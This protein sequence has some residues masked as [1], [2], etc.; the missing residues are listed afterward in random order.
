MKS[1]NLSDWALGHRSLV[2][3]FMIAFMAAGFFAYLQLGRQEDPDF[4]I[5]TMVVQAQ[6]PGAS[7]EEMTRQITDRIEKK[8]E[9]LE[10]LDYTK[11]VTVAGQ[12]TVF[13]Y[14]R[15]STKAADVKPTWIRVRNMIADIKGDFPQG[16]IGP[17]FNDRF[18]DVFGNIYA[19]TSDGLSQR[20]LRDHV[21]DIRA[22]VL[23]VPDVG[24][25]DIL[26]AQDEVIYLEF[27]TRKIAAL[28]LDVHAIMSSLQGQNAVA[29]SGVFQE[30]PERISVR[31][32]GQFTSEASLKAVNLRINDRFFP[33]TDVATI[34]RGYADPARTLFRYNGES[35]IALAIG[36]KSG[37]NLLHFGEALKEEMS[38]ITADLPVGVGVHLVADQPVVVEHAVSGF[39][40]ALFEAVII[41]L[42]ISFLSLGMR[43][44]LVVAI[45]IPLVLAITFVV[46]AYAG[47]SLQRISLGALIIAL[48]LLVDDAMIAVEM[49]VARLEVGDPLEKAAT[50][51]YTSTAFPMLTGTL[52]TVAGF[53][54]IGLNSSNAGEF[55]FTLFVVIAVSLI[56]SWIVAVLFTPLLGVTILP[57]RM[58]GHHEQKGRVAQLFTRLLLVCMHRRWTTIAVTVAAFLLALFGM[59][60]V[61]QQFFPSS[62]RAELVIDWNLPQNASIADTN[63]QMARFER[64]QL[65]G[66]NSVDHWSSY[67]GTGSPRFVLSFDVQTAN[68]WF[69]QMVVVTR[70]GIKARDQVKAQFEDYLRKTFPGTDTYVKLLEVGPPVGRPV[71]FRLSGPD[72]AKVRDLAQK[73]AGIVRSSPDL[74]NVV[75][76]WMEPA[77]VVKVD[78]LQDKARQLGVTSEDIASTLNS[79]LEGTPITQVR[80]SI[81]LVSVTGRATAAERASIDTLRDLQLTALGGQ[82]VPLGAVANLRYELEQPTIWRR[83]R[84]PTI[85]LKA[86]IVGNAQPKTVVDQLAPK[87]AEFTK[88]LPAGYSV[89]IGGSVEESAKSQAPIVAVVPLMLFVMATVL[90]IQ[91][92]SFHRLF[93]V[94]AVAPLAVIGVV[95]ALLPS[96]APLGFV[97]ILGVLALIGILVRNS[98]ILIVQIEDL[99]KEGRPA[100]DAVVEATEHRMRPILLTAAAASLALI[101]I[102]REIFWGPM[103]YA[104]MGGIIVGTLLTLLFL[105]ALYVAWFRIHPDHN[106]NSSMHEPAAPAHDISPEPVSAATPVPV[107]E[108]QI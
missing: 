17:G 57:A 39:T 78:V 10:S 36:M 14:L 60:F 23:T 101:P 73:L 30:G 16:V 82:A 49:M 38:R 20:Q 6:W 42:G 48:G 46:M 72:I 9:E 56:V 102:A 27:S 104:M 98:V 45:A 25:V 18:G 88:T 103:A 89:H 91:L 94:F 97:A 13:V 43:A 58:K 44:G 64:E 107:L 11:S 61:Q 65:Q 90:M 8:L 92:Q 81:Y 47:I 67:V 37:A 52:V 74:G 55:T 22:K 59:N 62:D 85:T 96:G 2:W 71:Q 4:T 76:D 95:M 105:P 66:S 93:L 21:E 75:F 7:P 28:G 84:I 79:V 15:D 80:D 108:P 99:R 63:S 34:T 77:R 29:P 5:K 3:Y 83:A 54:P 68:T 12:T 87:V 24:K 106:D 41:V 51:V 100:W 86:G 32:N 40:E 35:A 31:V 69:G 19:F 1:F 70:G 26:G 50:H 53:I 33:L